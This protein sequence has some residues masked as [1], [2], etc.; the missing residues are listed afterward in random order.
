[1]VAIRIGDSACAEAWVEVR[2]LTDH[3]GTRS[4]REQREDGNGGGDVE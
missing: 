3:L 2:P 4:A 1:M